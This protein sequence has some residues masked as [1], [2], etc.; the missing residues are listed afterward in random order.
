M[1]FWSAIYFFLQMK[2]IHDDN[3]EGLTNLKQEFIAKANSNSGFVEALEI[4]NPLNITIKEIPYKEAISIV[5]GFTTDKIYF[6]TEMEKEEIRMLT[7][8]FR[9]KQNGKYYRLQF[10]T[11][12]VESD[13]LIK[14]M[15]YLLLGLWITLLFTLYVVGKMIMSK[16]NKP[17]YALLDRLKSFRLDNRQMIDFTPTRIKEYAQ[18]N[19][20]VS[21]LLEKNIKAF[22]E[23]KI[24]IENTSHELQT[25]LTIVIA[26]LELLIEK[27]QHNKDYAEEIAD[28]LNILNRMKRLNANLLLLSKI[29]NR[30]FPETSPVDLRNVLEQVIADFE[31]LIDYKG[32][33]V[34]KTGNASPVKQM[35][36][37]LAYILFTNLIK[38]AVAH[39]QTDG[40]IMI[41]YAPNSITIAN[42]GK[43]TEMAVF[44]RY[45]SATV[46]EKSSGL[47]LSIVKSIADLYEINLTYRYDKVHVFTLYLK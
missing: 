16:A 18:L 10:F 46:E 17:F 8:A 1:L 2:E 29:K 3:D 44:S 39:N 11:S 22:S 33:R 24:F 30:Q 13:D 41:N 40:K 27:Y 26:K 38:N 25:P 23:Q 21:E 7:T 9:C 36:E 47:G 5:E 34:E 14:N 45:Q 19:K 4:H 15:F 28:V 37:D 12:T 6:A 31:E 43:E 35:N 20:S 42:S 32:I